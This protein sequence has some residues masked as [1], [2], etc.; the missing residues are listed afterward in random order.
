VV[1]LVVGKLTPIHEEE[2]RFLNEVKDTLGNADTRAHY[3]A[4]QS[5]FDCFA[6]LDDLFASGRTTFTWS[7]GRFEPDARA[8]KRNKGNKSE[9]NK[10]GGQIAELRAEL[11]AL[12]GRTDDAVRA[13]VADT[14]ARLQHDIMMQAAAASQL[15][16]QVQQLKDAAATAQAKLNATEQQASDALAQSQQE[17]IQAATTIAQLQHQ[18]QTLTV[19]LL[20]AQTAAA[21]AAESARQVVQSCMEQAQAAV[22]QAEAK[23]QEQVLGA[24]EVNTQLHARVQRLKASVTTANARAQKIARRSTASVM[25]LRVQVQGLSDDLAAAQAEAVRVKQL[26]E[27]RAK[28]QRACDEN[29]KTHTA[30]ME[31]TIASLRKQ[32]TGNQ[33]MVQLLT[34]LVAD[35]RLEQQTHAQIAAEQAKQRA[36]SQRCGS[37]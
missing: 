17:K 21:T 3:D 30:E 29:R 23:F 16:A 27:K 36:V 10:S 4:P 31:A 34:D 2:M 32:L 28:I 33:V 1:A 22:A 12:R 20:C 24:V 19:D 25:Q 7:N 35:L 26:D 14:E 6:G 8:P 5:S 9:G 37:G 18:A 13:A 11:E 15:R